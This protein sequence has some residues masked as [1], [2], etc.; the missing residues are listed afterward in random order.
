MSIDLRCGDVGMPEHI[1]DRTQ[2]GAA[3]EQVGC[4]RMTQRVRVKV[5]H[6]D[7]HTSTRHDRMHA[8]T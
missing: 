2:I 4:E 1:L 3:F 6:A 7:A 5:L 8:L